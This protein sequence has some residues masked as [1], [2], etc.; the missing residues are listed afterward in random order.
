MQAL[1]QDLLDRGQLVQMTLEYKRECRQQDT[2]VSLAQA[3]TPSGLETKSPSSSSVNGTASATAAQA[4]S[5][6]PGGAV[7]NGAALG[8]P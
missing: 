4:G 7:Q 5:A 1:P 6:R 8:T 3:C 2:V